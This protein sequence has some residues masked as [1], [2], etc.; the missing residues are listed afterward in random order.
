MKI[1]KAENTDLEKLLLLY[2]R[3]IDHQ[4]YDEY[5]ASWTKGIYPAESDILNHLENNTFYIGEVNG[6]IACRC[7]V[8]A[9]EDDIYRKAD[10][11]TKADEDETAVIHLLAVDHELRGRGYASRLVEFVK[12]ELKGKFEVIH[13]D[14]LAGNMPADRL[15][16]KAGFTCIG[17]Y[18]V[19]YEDLGNT[20]VDLYECVL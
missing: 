8:V 12:N 4:Q 19:W 20:A 18:P 5:G 1:R 7:A 3:V 10:W 17:R 16:R 6:M 11:I 9:G 2:D 15:Y 13:L 14:V